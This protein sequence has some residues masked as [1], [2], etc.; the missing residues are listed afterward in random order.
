MR[1]L[2]RVAAVL[3]VVLTIAFVAAS[4]APSAAKVSP[5]VKP[6]FDLYPDQSASKTV[7]SVLVNV[8]GEV[9]FHPDGCRTDPTV[10]VFCDAFRIKL[11]RSTAKDAINAVRVSMTW[12]PQ[13]TVPDLVLVAAGLGVGQLP[14]LDMYAYDTPD[15][16]YS[17]D[18]ADDDADTPGCQGCEGVGGRGT[19]VPEILGFQATQDEYDIVV[20]A[21]TGV[22]LDG[23]TITVAFSDE[24]FPPPVEALGD[25]AAPPAAESGDV[26]VA[27]PV[28]TSAPADALVPELGLAPIDADPDIAAIGLGTQERFD[29]VQLA[30][31]GATRTTAATTRPPSGPMLW[32]SLLAAPAGAAGFVVAWLRRRQ[33]AML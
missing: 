13:A 7:K 3:A 27:T 26:A 12:N 21:G 30:L 24:L 16:S 22:L 25:T 33:L 9:E 6:D 31:G 2:G 28:D 11:H 23:Y 1:G 20:Q 5:G 29:Q 19:V 4:P 15:H 8:A 32:L 18:T 17:Y 14:D 10:D